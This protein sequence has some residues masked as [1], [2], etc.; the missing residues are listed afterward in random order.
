MLL[1]SSES[2]VA[3]LVA[4]RLAQKSHPPPRLLRTRRTLNGRRGKAILIRKTSKSRS[5]AL[6]C[7]PFHKKPEHN[8]CCEALASC[9]QLVTLTYYYH[10]Y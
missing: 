6:G 2:A 10:L 7:Y 5:D 3:S 4:L 1:L 9:T 8:S